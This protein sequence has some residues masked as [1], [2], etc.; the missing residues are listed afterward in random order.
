MP[1]EGSPSDGHPSD[2][3]PDEAALLAELGAALAAPDVPDDVLA[4]ARAVYTWRTIDAE[5]A[6]ITY[7]SSDAGLTGAAS[8]RGAVADLRVLVF[9]AGGATIA[10]EVGP[11]EL[12]GQISPV[13]PGGAGPGRLETADGRVSAVPVDEFGCFSVSPVPHLRFRLVLEVGDLG[14]LVT[15]WV[16]L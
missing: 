12:L 6:R 9:A 11:R 16:T 13:P 4:T 14:P 10:L 2:P 1:H 3:T 15:D 8:V 7:D 5:L